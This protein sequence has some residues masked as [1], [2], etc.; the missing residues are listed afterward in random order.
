LVAIYNSMP[1]AKRVKKFKT[2]AAGAS[3]IWRSIQG[4]GEAAQPVAEPAQQKAHKK[5][6]DGAPAAQG[7]R[8]KGKASKK[9]TPAK[10]GWRWA[11]CWPSWSIVSAT[12]WM[13][14]RAGLI[15][16]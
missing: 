10:K 3:R 6:K 4:L 15:A 5:A 12:G 8:G 7:A 14:W 11:G 2:A 16:A 1:G 13:S 9:A